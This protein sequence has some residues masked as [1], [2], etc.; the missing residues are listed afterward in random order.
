[1]RT[2]IIDAPNESAQGYEYF[3]PQLMFLDKYYN[4]AT[5]FFPQYFYYCKSVVMFG[6][7]SLMPFLQ[8]KRL[9]QPVYPR[10]R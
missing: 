7:P 1:M 9:I 10:Y 8:E 5:D 4:T 2:D 3:T 6:I